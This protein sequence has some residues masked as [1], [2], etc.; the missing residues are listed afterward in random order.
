MFGLR[1]ENKYVF[2]GSDK[3]ESMR[4]KGVVR[5]VCR[6]YTQGSPY[7][8]NGNLPRSSLTV[9]SLLYLV[10]V[11]SLYAANSETLPF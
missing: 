5:S 3:V 2:F 11:D 7:I 6:M 9:A 8:G 1:R 4:V 10:M